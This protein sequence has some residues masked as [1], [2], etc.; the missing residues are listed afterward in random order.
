MSKVKQGTRHPTRFPLE[1]ANV[2]TD[3]LLR[4]E[5]TPL[6]Q[7]AALD[8]AGSLSTRAR[9]VLELDALELDDLV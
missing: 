9:E 5:G 6:P 3:R 2:D 4:L 1:M 7:G 8:E